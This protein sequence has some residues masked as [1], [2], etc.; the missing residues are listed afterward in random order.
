MGTGD[1]SG[2]VHGKGN[3]DLYDGKRRVEVCRVDCRV[4]LE[5]SGLIL[6]Q[7]LSPFTLGAVGR[8]KGPTDLGSRPV[9]VCRE[10]LGR[11]WVLSRLPSF[12]PLLCIGVFW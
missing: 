9:V 5:Y 10:G 3:G 12:T 4:F 6:V 2:R 1:G 7:S 11:T 8:W